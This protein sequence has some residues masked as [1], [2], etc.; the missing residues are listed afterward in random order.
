[1]KLV[2]RC[3]FFLTM[4]TIAP[5]VQAE[6]WKGAYFGVNVGQGDV[7]AETDSRGVPGYFAGVGGDAS[8]AIAQASS[9]TGRYASSHKGGAVGAH[10]GYNWPSGKI[11]LGLES[12]IQFTDLKDNAAL[13]TINPVTG[14]P[15]NPMSANVR[16]VNTV[17][18]LVTLRGRI[19]YVNDQWLLYGTGGVAV[20]RVNTNINYK[21]SYLSAPTI[22]FDDLNAGSRSTRLGFVLGA[23]AEYAIAKNWAVRV[24]YLYYDLGKSSQSYNVTSR[25]PATGFVASSSALATTDWTLSTLRVGIS[26]RF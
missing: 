8:G 14:Y 21:G 16:Q 3:F 4:I 6:Q 13:N 5:F 9:L 19:G 26:Y 20:G 17:D 11:F 22:V 23:G 10:L 15:G 18:Y 1:M 12:D 2:K 24:E 25:A 7:Q